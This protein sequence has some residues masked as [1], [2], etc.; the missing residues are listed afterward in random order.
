MDRKLTAILS[1]DV[2]GFSKLM[3]DDE[4]GTLGRLKSHRLETFDPTVSEH[5]GRIIKLMGDGALV[6]FASVVDAVNCAMAVQSAL[7]QCGG[8]IRLR[9]GINL[10]DVIIDG[11]DIY[12]DGVNIASRLEALAEPG[13]VCVS[14][15]VQQAVRMKTGPIFRDLG[16]QNLKNI[17][18]SVR[19]WHWSAPNEQDAIEPTA[20]STQS[21]SEKPSIA[22]LPFDNMSGDPEQEYFADGVS[23]DIITAL[24]RI[25]WLFVI[26]RNSTFVHKGKAVDVR[27]LAQELGVRYVLEGSVRKAGNRVRITTQLIDAESSNHLWANRY[28]RELDD[29]FALQDEITE[30]IVGSIDSELR[31]AEQDR[32]KH[33]PTSDLN[34]WDLYQRGNWH[35]NRFTKQGNEKAR[36]LFETATRADPNFALAYAGCALVGVSDVIMR[37]A[38]QSSETVKNAIR[39][40]E[41]AKALDDREALTHYALG[42]AFCLAG[43]TDSGIASLEKAIALNPNFALAHHGMAF[44]LKAG[45]RAEDSLAHV[46][47]AIKLSPNDPL[48]WTFYVNNASAHYQLKDYKLAEHWAGKAVR[49]NEREYWPNLFRAAALAQQDKLDEARA[50][51]TKA[52]ALNPEFSLSFVAQSLPGYNQDYFEHLVEGLRKAGVPQ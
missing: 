8:P 36:Q 34:A 3:E 22:V 7:V 42:R 19:A 20:D 41:K 48:L 10:G 4:E 50:A 5:N 14:D 35:L 18:Q 45:G 29:I 15:I 43:D 33:K 9:I 39:L 40:A 47:M 27:R 24:S 52:L 17:A 46:A 6:E 21:A 26:A 1:A 2:V 31:G 12:G 16:E 49:E 25:R 44:A 23:E 38:D 37:I 13:G 11:D 30:T 28:D 32:A 51:V